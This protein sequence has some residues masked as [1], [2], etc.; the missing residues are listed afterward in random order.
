MSWGDCL[1]ENLEP[2]AKA[3]DGKGSHLEFLSKWTGLDNCCEERGHM[4]PGGREG[5]GSI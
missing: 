3:K 2:A 1:Q 4:T 5:S